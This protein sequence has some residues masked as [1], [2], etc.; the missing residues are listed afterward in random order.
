METTSYTP[1]TFVCGDIHGNYKGLKQTLERSELNYEKDTLIFL[2]DI[3]DGHSETF[4]CVEELLKIKNLIAIRGNHDYWWL[5]WLLKGRHPAEWT[6]GSKAT[7]ESYIKNMI[8]SENF[9]F[10]DYSTGHARTRLTTVDIPQSHVIFFKHQIPY[11]VDN[12]NRLFVHGGFNRHYA[13]N[14]EDHNPEDVLMWDRDLWSQALSWKAA[15]KGVLD[16]KPKFKMFNDFK[17]V[18]IGHTPTQFWDFT[19]PM[20]AANVWNLDTGGGFYGHVSI[21]NVETKEY[22][23]SDDAKSLYPNYRGRRN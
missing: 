21:M 4:E 18:F 14:D 1:K 2:G 20:N 10:Y 15:S 22:W 13:I 23:Q 19:T 8:D 6:Q 17:E 11:Y 9:F 3:V 5:Y 16:E 7:A 12:Q